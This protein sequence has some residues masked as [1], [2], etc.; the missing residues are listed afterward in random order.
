MSSVPPTCCFPRSLPCFTQ[1]TQRQRRCRLSRLSRAARYS[2]SRRSSFVRNSYH[3]RLE[4]VRRYPLGM[5]E[6]NLSHNSTSGHIHF[7]NVGRR[8]RRQT[9]DYRQQQILGL[10]VSSQQALPAKVSYHSLPFFPDDAC[11]M[12]RRQRQEGTLL[13]VL[14]TQQ[15]TFARRL[16]PHAFG[17]TSST[18]L[19]ESKAPYYTHRNRR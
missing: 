13:I 15:S 17:A 18:T 7:F 6:R 10:E 16:K 5:M 8:L 19:L 12:R 1:A 9:T 4:N 2:T 14:I 11:I 3:L